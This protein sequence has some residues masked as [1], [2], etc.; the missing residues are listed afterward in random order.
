[1]DK[2][3]TTAL[4][5]I[6]GVISSVF[7]FR[8][9][10]PAVVESSEALVGMG[11]RIDERVKSQIEII[12]SI[13]N[14]SLPWQA[15]V[16]VKNIGSTTI[17]GIDRCDVFFGKEGDFSRIPY[18]TG[19]PNWTYA[20]ENDTDWKPTA[21]LKITIDLGMGNNLDGNAR[22]FLKVLLPNGVSDEDYFTY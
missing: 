12:H 3:I 22:Y 20:L 1:M 13:E 11:R 5:I 9:F 16:W 15:F 2:T 10:Y 17:K 21:T 18:E 8:A 4:L 14:P 19:T 6:A 7:V